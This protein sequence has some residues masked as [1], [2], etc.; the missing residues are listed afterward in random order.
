[1]ARRTVDRRERSGQWP[2]AG[3]LLVLGGHG[4]WTE[5]GRVATRKTLEEESHGVPSQTQG[6]WGPP[7]V[8]QG[9][10]W[11]HQGRGGGG[12]MCC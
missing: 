2:A 3:S 8:E 11:R 4:D 7:V 12:R 1:M 10:V 5:D 6:R 9:R